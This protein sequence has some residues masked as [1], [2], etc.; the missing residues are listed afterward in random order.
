M[1]KGNEDLIYDADGTI[2]NDITSDDDDIVI[3]DDKR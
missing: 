1:K 3:V 2:L